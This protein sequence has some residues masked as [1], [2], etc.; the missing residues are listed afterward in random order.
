MPHSKLIKKESDF[1]DQGPLV[2]ETYPPPRHVVRLAKKSAKD[3]ASPSRQNKLWVAK[4]N[5]INPKFAEW[6]ESI[7]GGYSS[8]TLISEFEKNHQLYIDHIVSEYLNF[9]RHSELKSRLVTNEAGNAI[10]AKHSVFIPGLKTF[11]EFI[12]R[13]SK[14]EAPA[15]MAVSKN[16]VPAESFAK[17]MEVLLSEND[18]EKI[19]EIMEAEL[20]R[21]QA[22]LNFLA[23][24]AVTVTPIELLRLL[25][26]SGP[27]KKRQTLASFADACALV[28]RLQIQDLHDG[29]IGIDAEGNIQLF[30]VEHAFQAYLENNV[31]FERD[32]FQHITQQPN[33]SCFSWIDGKQTPNFYAQFKQEL[34]ADYNFFERCV[35]IRLLKEI[36]CPDGFFICLSGENHIPRVNNPGERICQLFIETKNTL[37]NKLLQDKEFIEYLL[38]YSQEDFPQ[39]IKDFELSIKIHKHYFER[40]P[41][42]APGFMQRLEQG[43]ASLMCDVHASLAVI[44]FLKKDEKVPQA[45]RMFS[46][47]EKLNKD[48]ITCF[49]A[50]DYTNAKLHFEKVL[51]HWR[52]IC[53]G[54]NPN[55]I[56]VA[57]KCST[58]YNLAKTHLALS[59]FNEALSLLEEAQKITPNEKYLQQ[60]EICKDSLASAQLP[61]AT[62]TSLTPAQ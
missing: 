4:P 10:T 24:D 20:S 19:I 51:L 62:N 37:K 38:K 35:F 41:I 32:Q 28:Q 5:K 60:I 54:E 53:S 36:I 59:E 45:T 18:P 49:K 58:L 55:A 50:G 9:M 57:N 7:P 43:Y 2:T 21:A 39:I 12:P 47:V 3:T 29:N 15:L 6:F 23:A 40:S 11:S 33:A 56:A 14:S 44:P 61:G 22:K 13:P 30:D 26:S 17:R 34:G 27:E 1:I 46:S 25:E 8:S 42:L 52:N 48:G 31:V 16:Q